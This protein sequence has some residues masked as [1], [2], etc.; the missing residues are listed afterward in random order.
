M[1]RF[2]RHFKFVLPL[3]LLPFAPLA[4]SDDDGSDDV[5]AAENAFLGTWI[6]NRTGAADG[7]EMVFNA[8]GTWTTSA[9]VFKAIA[10]DPPVPRAENARGT[11]VSS[12]EQAFGPMEDSDSGPGTMTATLDGSIL[13]VDFFFAESAANA[14]V[15]YSGM[16]K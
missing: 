12:E 9:N 15:Y 3:A 13:S 16:K 7:V 10:L 1:K 14:H 6:L 8:D 2:F 4:C 11:Y 5:P